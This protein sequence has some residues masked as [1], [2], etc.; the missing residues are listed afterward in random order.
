MLLGDAIEAVR[1][2]HSLSVGKPWR[3][4]AVL[5]TTAF[6]AG[7]IVKSAVLFLVFSHLPKRSR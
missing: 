5:A 7:V 1:L 6:W 4:F 3:K 2:Q